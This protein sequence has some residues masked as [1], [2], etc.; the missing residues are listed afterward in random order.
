VKRALLLGALL[1]WT[2]R[3]EAR[4][5]FVLVADGDGFTNSTPV[6]PVA[7][8]QGT[9][10]GDQRRRALARALEIWGAALDSPVPIVV[11]ATFPELSCT[12][13]GAVLGQAYAWQHF[14][15]LP[16]S[17]PGSPFYASALAERIVGRELSASEP[18]LAIELNASVDDP[19][20]ED[21]AGRWYYG[22][23]SDTPSGQNDL[24]QVALHELAHGLGFASAV[25]PQTGRS[26]LEPGLDAFST[27]ILDLDQNKHWDALTDAQRAV[28]AGN[29]R[30]LVFDGENARTMARAALATGVPSLRLTPTPD[31]ASLR[32]VSDVELAI[33]AA[34]SPVTG[35]LV[36]ANPTDACTQLV[37]DVRG[38]VVLLESGPDCRWQ[39]ALARLAAAGA[40]GAL[41]VVSAPAM[42]PAEPLDAYGYGSPAGVRAVTVSAQAG[43]AI[44]Q[45][46]NTTPVTATLGGD[47]SAWLGAD[48]QGRPLLFASQPALRGSSLSHFDSLARPNL[49]MEAYVQG[50]SNHDVDLTLAVLRDIG[51]ARTCGNGAVD[52]DE[53]CDLG[54]LN[55]NI[56]GTPCLTNCRL[57]GCGDG[58]KEP[59]EACD[60]GANNDDLIAGACRTTCQTAH[61]GDGVMELGEV[62]DQGIGNS[63]VTPDTCR[64]DCTLARC[65]DGVI[66]LR[67]SC[68]GTP[69]CSATCTSVVDADASTGHADDAGIRPWTDEVEPR[70]E[71]HRDGCALGAGGGACWLVLAGVLL[72][73][74]RRRIEA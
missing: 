10:L 47:A 44:N 5:D 41:F 42:S 12:D 3:V 35:P 27:H 63:D 9:T 13:Q 74:R 21:I 34:K 72:F 51:W 71:G 46:L 6:Q 11:R 15:N 38:A 55:A 48:A 31:D 66:D 61:C 62:C 8:N 7:G 53:Q 52:A 28:S 4:A 2:S 23:D 1:A 30:R 22:F 68:D 32:A 39:D 19:D 24:I 60:E 69:G 43:A 50:G 64:S 37:A 45:L 17:A 65:G 57:P 18:D 25:D 36:L 70:G 40:A 20:C 14:R 59:G 54:S 73:R 29:V 33:N 16:G 67:E 49:L 58:V 56:A 26:Q